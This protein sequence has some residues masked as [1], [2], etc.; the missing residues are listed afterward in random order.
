[1]KKF[2]WLFMLLSLFTATSWGQEMTEIKKILVL[3]RFTAQTQKSYTFYLDEDQASGTIKLVLY[4]TDYDYDEDGDYTDFSIT[5]NG[6]SV[7]N[8]ESLTEYGLGKDGTYGKAVL[9]ISAYV[10]SGTNTI[11]I[12]DTE[13]EGQVDYVYLKWI[14]ITG[15]EKASVDDLKSKLSKSLTGDLSE[16]KKILVLER[17]NC[18]TERSYTFYLNSSQASGTV[19]LV[20]YG[21]DYDYDDDGDYTDFAIYVNG[22]S[23]IYIDRLTDYGLG[24]D[25]NYGKAE[26]DISSYVKSGTNTITLEN[27]EDDGQVDYVYLKWL[28][29]LAP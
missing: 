4:G 8:I 28:K 27:T 20:L 9:D 6:H 23:V 3:E 15:E 19:K 13:V 17:F 12:E 29:I 5:V 14:K 22:N 7:I 16:V 25:G 1:M 10:K 24:K 21:T 11:T 2:V 26:F 18:Q